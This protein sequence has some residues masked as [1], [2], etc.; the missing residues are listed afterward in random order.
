MQQG[1]VSKTKP[2]NPI[3]GCANLSSMDCNYTLAITGNESFTS[4]WRNFVLL[5][6][7]KLF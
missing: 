5:F 6:F 7:A 4:L 1:L 3:T 2:L